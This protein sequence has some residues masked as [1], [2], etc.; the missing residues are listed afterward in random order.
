MHLAVVTVELSSPTTICL[1][2]SKADSHKDP[3]K[4]QSSWTSLA[5]DKKL[6]AASLPLPANRFRKNVSKEESKGKI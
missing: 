5:A 3:L 6:T 2:I 1:H 4:Q